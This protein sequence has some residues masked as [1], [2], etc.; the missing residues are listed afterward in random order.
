MAASFLLSTLNGLLIG[1]LFSGENALSLDGAITV[2][3]HWLFAD[4]PPL[5]P[6]ECPPSP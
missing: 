5:D 2:L 6:G 1:F 4:A 3:R